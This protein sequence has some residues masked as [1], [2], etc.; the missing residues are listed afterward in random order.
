MWTPHIVSKQQRE[1]SIADGQ[2]LT[3]L[4]QL[5]DGH[6]L[7]AVVLGLEYLHIG[8]HTVRYH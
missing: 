5:L 8:S 4:P 6:N 2:L 7:H 3:F 1:L